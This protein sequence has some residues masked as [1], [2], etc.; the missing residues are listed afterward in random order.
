MHTGCWVELVDTI[1]R[2]CTRPALV[3]GI[4]L[5]PLVVVVCP[6][7]FLALWLTLVIGIYAWV[8][9][10]AFLV[11]TLS[12]LREITSIDDQRLIQYVALG[13]LLMQHQR[14]PEVRKRCY[15]PFGGQTQ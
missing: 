11:P 4:P 14:K 1:F 13:R 10:I 3:V 5:V 2:G 9:T 12:V 15:L 7:A 8:W 6:A